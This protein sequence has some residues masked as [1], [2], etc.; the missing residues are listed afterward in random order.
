[1]IAAGRHIAPAL[2]IGGAPSGI[3]RCRERPQVSHGSAVSI[4]YR[5]AAA[6]PEATDLT[7]PGAAAEGFQEL[8]APG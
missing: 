1:M 8:L 7:L 6:L 4:D 2:Q 5:G 3:R